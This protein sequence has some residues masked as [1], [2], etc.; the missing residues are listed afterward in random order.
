[1][2][3]E[4]R[5]CAPRDQDAITARAARQQGC[6]GEAVEEDGLGLGDPEGLQ[7]KQARAWLGA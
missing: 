7:G 4:H 1:M 2:S 6:L 5:C 3:A